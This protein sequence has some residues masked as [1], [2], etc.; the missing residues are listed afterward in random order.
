MNIATDLITRGS[1]SQ[2]LRDARPKRIVLAV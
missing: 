2:D 1:R